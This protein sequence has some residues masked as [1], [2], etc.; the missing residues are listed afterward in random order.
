MSRSK[1]AVTDAPWFVLPLH[2][3]PR[4]S[5]AVVAGLGQMQDRYCSKNYT[6]WIIMLQCLG[7]VLSKYHASLAQAASREI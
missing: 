2:P 4:M 1:L 3:C 6:L 5:E 7:S